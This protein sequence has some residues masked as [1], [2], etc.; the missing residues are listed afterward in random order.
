MP[1]PTCNHTMHNLG[2]AESGKRTFW[3]PR[4][5]TIK[6]EVTVHASITG[7]GGE[8]TR[9]QWEEHEAPKW[10]APEGGVSGR[11]RLLALFAELVVSPWAIDKCREYLRG[12]AGEAQEAA[13]QVRR[14]DAA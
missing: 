10:T 5:G 14:A 7:D 12:R 2:L 8:T 11:Q 6:T 9:R 13:D 4:C 3:C 1:C